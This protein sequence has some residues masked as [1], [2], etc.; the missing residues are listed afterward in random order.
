[1]P[2]ARVQQPT[3]LKRYHSSPP[4][5]DVEPPLDGGERVQDLVDDVVDRGCRGHDGNAGG[6]GGDSDL[7]VARRHRLVVVLGILLLLD[8]LVNQVP[9]TH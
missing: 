9:G 3:D 6:H 4:L 5:L 2:A 7:Q 1:M 8:P